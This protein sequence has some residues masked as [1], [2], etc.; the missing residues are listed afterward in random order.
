[1]VSDM[2]K[3]CRAFIPVFLAAMPSANETAKYPIQIGMP[4]SI[5]FRNQLPDDLF[6]E[7]AAA[8]I[9]PD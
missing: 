9:S 5:P 3:D 6:S 7:E 8:G 1:M 4:A 2:M